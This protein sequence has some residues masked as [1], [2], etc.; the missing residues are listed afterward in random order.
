[1]RGKLGFEPRDSSLVIDSYKAALALV[2]AAHNLKATLRSSL[3]GL[4]WWLAH[5]LL[6]ICLGGV[7]LNAQWTHEVNKAIK[8][9]KHCSGL[10]SQSEVVHDGHRRYSETGNASLI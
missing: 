3:Q 2:V 1:M 9:L 4:R 10:A 7:D 8:R 6:D 5:G